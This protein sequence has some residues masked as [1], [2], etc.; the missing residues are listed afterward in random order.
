MSGTPVPAPGQEPEAQIEKLSDEVLRLKGKVKGT[1]SVLATAE[2]QIRDLR[3]DNERLLKAVDLYDESRY[4]VQPK[5]AKRPRDKHDHHAT[6]VTFLSD[7]H[8]GER[9]DEREMNGVNAYNLEVCERR[10]ERFFD[11]TILVAERYLTGVTT[12]GIVLALGGDLVSGDIHDELEQTNEC[13]TYEAV[14]FLVPRLVAG[15]TKLL[16]TFGNVH[17]VS[18]PGNHGRDSKKPRSKGRSAH[19]AD[20]HV[21]QLVRMMLE[22]IIRTGAAPVSFSIPKSF[23]AGFKVYDWSF[24]LEHGDTFKFSGTSEIG[25]I[26]PVKRGTLRKSNRLLAEDAPMD[27]NLIGHFHQFMPMAPQGFVVNG[28]LKGYDEYARSWHLRPERAQQALLV[29]TP[30]WGITT[31]TPVFVQPRDS[32]RGW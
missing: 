29:V 12:D 4:V 28:S 24:N 6:F 2:R 30:E 22:P 25:S 9:V 23:D 26:G 7:V 31:Q 14:E 17:V 11:R 3:L 18:A 32:G 10:L 20:T 15:I 27:Y 13:S 16:D 21:A 5:W 19:N 1:E 8:A